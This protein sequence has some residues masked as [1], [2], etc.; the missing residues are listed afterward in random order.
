MD[1]FP[2]MIAID[3]KVDD[4]IMNRKDP[5]SLE[6]IKLTPGLFLPDY[7]EETDVGPI[8]EALYAQ[9]D[10]RNREQVKVKTSMVFQTVQSERIGMVGCSLGPPIL[11]GSQK[12][13][14]KDKKD[15]QIILTGQNL[16]IC[17][18]ILAFYTYRGSVNVNSLGHPRFLRRP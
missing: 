14:F 8:I 15:P 10:N 12:N 7:L 2:L 13:T 11:R 1:L 16:R 9:L 5:I 6:T 3:L 18:K 17:L 4:G